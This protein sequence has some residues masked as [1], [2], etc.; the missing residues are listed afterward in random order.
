MSQ[1]LKVCSFNLNKKSNLLGEKCNSHN[2]VVKIVI[3]LHKELQ[4]GE[5]MANIS[6]IMINIAKVRA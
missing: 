1:G 5:N 4:L 3:F 6:L 2:G